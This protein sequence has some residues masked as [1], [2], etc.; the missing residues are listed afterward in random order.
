VHA[1]LLLLA[2]ASS[3]TR[4]A[5]ALPEALGSP[6][7]V[8]CQE[9]VEDIR[10]SFTDGDWQAILRGDVVTAEVPD[11]SA[12]SERA[13]VRVAGLIPSPPARVWEVLADFESRP[14]WQ[15]HAKEVRIARVDGAR[16]WVDEQVSF[17]LVPIRCRI[18]NTLDPEHGAIEFELDPSVPHDIGGTKGSWLLRPF[19]GGTETLAAYRGWIDTGRHVPA[20]VRRILLERELPRILSGLRDEVVRI[21]G[22]APARP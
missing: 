15:P 9:R 5:V 7:C 13:S 8:A 22:T 2:A 12:E 18:V 17:F 19:A 3:V 21:A 16:V 11:A 6:A 1:T 14:D 10:S 20:F 4:A